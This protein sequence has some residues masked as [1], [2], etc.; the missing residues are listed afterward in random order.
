MTAKPTTRWNLVAWAAMT[1]ACGTR[2]SAP[3]TVASAGVPQT[4]LGPGDVFEVKVLGDTELSTIYRVSSDGT[5]HFP[6]IGTL[7]VAGMTAG[8]VGDAIQQKLSR[9]FVEP[10]VSI[11]VREFNSKKIFVFG[12]VQRPGT[13]SFEDGM[14]IIQAITLAGGFDK[15]AN[16]DTAYVT[17]RVDGREQR[18]EVSIQDISAGHAPNFRMEPGDILFVAETAF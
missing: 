12:Q 2:V 6:M 15:L 18:M 17:R 10:D 14:N 11:F 8:Q 9:F 7:S 1:T 4:V 3:P 5:I 13:F 16:Q